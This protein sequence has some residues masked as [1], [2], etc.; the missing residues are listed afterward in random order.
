[1]SERERRATTHK[2]GH[3]W[4]VMIHQATTTFVVIHFL[5]LTHSFHIFIHIISTTHML[6]LQK[7]LLQ[8]LEFSDVYVILLTGQRVEVNCRTDATA[9]D[10]FDLVVSH[11]NLSENLLFGLTVLKGIYNLGQKICIYL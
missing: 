5:S 10:V 6:K 8:R 7:N 3:I 4:L 9:G 11:I 2:V 1:V